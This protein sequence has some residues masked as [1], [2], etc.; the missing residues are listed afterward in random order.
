MEGKVKFFVESKGYGFIKGDDDND[1]FVHISQTNEENLCEGDYVSFS[2]E[3][4]PKGL[5]A[6]N[7]QK[8]E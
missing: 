3:K 4:G 2:S 5:C 6:K 7:V 1:Y 8:I